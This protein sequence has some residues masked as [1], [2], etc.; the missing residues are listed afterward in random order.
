MSWPR[1]QYIQKSVLKAFINFEYKIGC[2]TWCVSKNYS[3]IVNERKSVT[4]E[5]ALRLSQ[6]PNSTAESWLSLQKSY[7]LWDTVHNT[8]D[9]KS[10]RPIANMQTDSSQNIVTLLSKIVQELCRSIKVSMEWFTR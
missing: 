4:P 7:D 8:H 5:L 3:S 2:N 10:V 9:W 6:V 1:R